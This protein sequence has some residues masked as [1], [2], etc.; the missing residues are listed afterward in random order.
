MDPP[1]KSDGLAHVRGIQFGAGMAAIGVHV[2]APLATGFPVRA[3][4]HPEGAEVKRRAC[5][6]TATTIQKDGL[7]S[8]RLYP[9]SHFQDV[10]SK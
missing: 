2:F 10:V 3:D 1:G 7:F 4:T 8:N 6:T 9:P 5:R